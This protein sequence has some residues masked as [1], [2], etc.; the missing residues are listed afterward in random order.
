MIEPNKIDEIHDIGKREMKSSSSS[1]TPG[2]TKER[3]AVTTKKEINKRPAVK[4][5]LLKS[6]SKTLRVG[7]AHSITSATD[8]IKS[9]ST[10]HTDMTIPSPTSFKQHGRHV[11][12]LCK[13]SLRR[14]LALPDVVDSPGT[15]SPSV[16]KPTMASTDIPVKDGDG[17]SF[18]QPAPSLISRQGTNNVSLDQSPLASGAT[19]TEDRA[20]KR[21]SPR[22]A[23]QSPRCS[24]PEIS[25]KMG[26][27]LAIDKDIDD[28][29]D[30]TPMPEGFSWSSLANKSHSHVQGSPRASRTTDVGTSSP[31]EKLKSD[32][33]S[34]NNKPTAKKTKGKKSLKEK[35]ATPPTKS[36]EVAKKEKERDKK[37]LKKS[38][39]KRSKSAKRGQDDPVNSNE[40]Q[41]QHSMAAAP[42]YG[43]L[44]IGGTASLCRD[45]TFHNSPSAVPGLL[46]SP[47]GKRNEPSAVNTRKSPSRSILKRDNHEFENHV[48]STGDGGG[49]SSPKGTEA[50]PHRIHHFRKNGTGRRSRT[51]SDQQSL[52]SSASDQDKNGIGDCTTDNNDRNLPGHMPIFESSFNLPQCDQSPSSRVFGGNHSY[53]WNASDSGR[54]DRRIQGSC[55]S[56]DGSDKSIKSLS[57][58]GEVW[59]G[60][61]VPKSTNRTGTDGNDA[62]SQVAN[63]SINRP[64][65]VQIMNIDLALWESDDDET[66][67]DKEDDGRIIRMPAMAVRKLQP[68]KSTIPFKKK[69]PEGRHSNR[70]NQFDTEEHIPVHEKGDDYN[71]SSA[72]GKKKEVDASFF[73]IPYTGTGAGR[74]RSAYDKNAEWYCGSDDDDNSKGSVASDGSSVLSAFRPKKKATMVPVL[75]TPQS[76]ASMDLDVLIGPEDQLDP[77]RLPKDSILKNDVSLLR[78]SEILILSDE[79]SFLGK[80]DEKIQQIESDLQSDIEN[81]EAVGS[82]RIEDEVIAVPGSVTGD[83]VG[84]SRN[85]IF[86]R[87]LSREEAFKWAMVALGLFLTLNIILAVIFLSR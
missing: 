77:G 49:L 59:V 9:F 52:P 27:P 61:M 16:G 33:I 36:K 58:S 35:A 34:S 84:N 44:G 83:G 3:Q 73:P 80:T 47:S 87:R 19:P 18:V 39:R 74:P 15:I 78:A 57:S 25:R 20:S 21:T 2:I 86:L 45:D 28:H 71:L 30:S 37:K 70:L 31:S 81:G 66:S 72:A 32:Q 43:S 14:P 10:A 1:Q 85:E 75:T 13:S 26:P 22:R 46:L 65:N 63:S 4:V 76:E 40:K 11:S 41:S 55:F 24:S 38:S 69:E 29:M 48:K 64:S 82:D 7:D 8:T 62:I 53:L 17:T 60:S 54:Q 23:C 42:S 51:E 56:E 12:L 79:M 6:T 67:L 5:K 68:A 50:S